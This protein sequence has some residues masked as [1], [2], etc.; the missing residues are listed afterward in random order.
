MLAKSFLLN[1][2]KKRGMLMKK[3]MRVT[4]LALV[5]SV[6]LIG[7]GYAA[8]GT[9]ITDNTTLNTGHWEIVLE[10]DVA[11]HSLAASDTITYAKADGTN[12]STSSSTVYGT[13]DASH[14]SGGAPGADDDYVYTIAPSIIGNTCNFGFYNL[15][16]GTTAITNYEVRNKGSIPARISDIKVLC[17]DKNGAV[18][19]ATGELKKLYDSIV[20]TGNISKHKGSGP[21]TV[22]KIIPAGTTLANLETTLKGL[23]TTNDFV[24]DP[25]TSSDP[26]VLD[27]DE[28][29]VNDL[30]FSIPIN[31]LNGSEGMDQSLKVSISYNFT[32]YNVKN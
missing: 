31:S 8:W 18:V 12:S 24:L 22:T 27:S 4:A 10:N 3:K 13:V 25:K 1:H 15:H 16:P 9:Q 14:I 2:I 29:E 30:S 17:T 28:M 5:M 7:A 19:P 26:S 11:G 20:V 23:L 32:Q 21:S 6:A